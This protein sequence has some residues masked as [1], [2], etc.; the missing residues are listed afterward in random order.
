MIRLLI[1]VLLL[2]ACVVT[3]VLT[4]SLLNGGEVSERYITALADEKP[5]T[6]SDPVLAMQPERGI[7]D[8]GV[9]FRNVGGNIDRFP[10][11]GE[12]VRI[13]CAVSSVDGQR[14]A[15]PA[16]FRMRHRHIIGLR[17]CVA[18]PPPPDVAGG[19]KQKN[20]QEE[21]ESSSHL[22]KRIAEKAPERLFSLKNT[23]KPRL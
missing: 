12:S 9:A 10:L 14:T 21:T 15:V 2:I 4:G 23:G 16:L 7:A 18:A 5:V 13:G 20:R 3:V 8:A 11:F 1:G 17:A 6:L 22:P 19:A